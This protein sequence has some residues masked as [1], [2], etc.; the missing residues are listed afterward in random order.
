MLKQEQ[1]RRLI[2]YYSLIYYIIV[3]QEI[4][5]VV[6]NYTHFHYLH[7][8]RAIVHFFITK[9]YIIIINVLYCAYIILFV[10]FVINNYYYTKTQE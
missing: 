2:K 4:F 8:K 1:K 9:N 3:L 10:H 6:V 5:T 7:T